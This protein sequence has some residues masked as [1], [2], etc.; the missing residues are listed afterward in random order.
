MKTKLRNLSRSAL[1]WAV[2]QALNPGLSLEAFL[3]DYGGSDWN[4]IYDQDQA[5]SGPLLEQHRICT[6]VD[7][8]GVW[9]AYIDD[10]YSEDGK[11]FMQS[12]ATR[13]E[14]G[15]RC[16]LASTGQVEVEIPEQVLAV[17]ED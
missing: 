9:L 1:N 10:G 13:L 15:L 11:R 4:Y 12:G 16:L 3:A 7:H 17:E 5:V 14:A 2:A 8:S 6:T